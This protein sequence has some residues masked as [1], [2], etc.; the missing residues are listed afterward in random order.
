MTWVA[1]V[2]LWTLLSVSQVRSIQLQ[3][4]PTSVNVG[5]IFTVAWTRDL[6]DPSQFPLRSVNAS[7]G[8]GEPLGL[9]VAFAPTASG[10]PA[11]SG[12]ETYTALIPGPFYVTAVTG[13]S[14]S[15]LLAS[16]NQITVNASGSDSS[17]SSTVTTT[18]VSTVSQDLSTKSSISQTRST[19][20]TGSQTQSQTESQTESQLTSQ[21]ESQTTTF[22]PDGTSMT[23]STL[24]SPA[25]TSSSTTPDSTLKST[26]NTPVIIGVVIGVIVLIALIALAVFICLRRRRRKSLAVL[27]QPFTGSDPSGSMVALNDS[28]PTTRPDHQQ[29]RLQPPDTHGGVSHLVSPMFTAPS[30]YYETTTSESLSDRK[31][32]L[33]SCPTATTVPDGRHPASIPY[34]AFQ[35]SEDGRQSQLFTGNE[36]PPVYNQEPT[37]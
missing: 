1:N 24:F 36:P 29:L 8:V 12:K 19:T 2:C 25:V 20:T 5:D 15:V 31:T 32:G 17:S 9:V 30:I 35:L 18:V 11:A 7:G 33:P 13:S 23:A 26:R 37:L 28:G 4:S 34:R 14:G 3:L 22:S 16:S 21:T 6:G 27:P 10:T